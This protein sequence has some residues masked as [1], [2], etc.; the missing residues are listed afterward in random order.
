MKL[1]SIETYSTENVSITKVKQTAVMKAGGKSRLIIRIFQ[2]WSCTGRWSHG[3]WVKMSNRAALES[4]S[5]RVTERSSSFRP[6]VPGVDWIRRCGICTGSWQAR[7]FVSCWVHTRPFPVYA[8]AWALRN[9]NQRRGGAAGA[10]ARQTRYTAF[11]FR[12]ASEVARC[13]WVAWPDRR[14]CPRDAESDGRR[15]YLAR[16]RQFGY[17]PKKRSKSADG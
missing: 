1:Q 4:L 15:Y 16:R 2:P 6:C 9:H 8:Q 3:R 14:D 17:T 5:D 11:K 13:G 10:A 7:A 12:I